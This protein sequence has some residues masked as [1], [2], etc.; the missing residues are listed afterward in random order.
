MGS[1]RV[2]VRFDYKGIRMGKLFF[3]GKS[4]EQ[5]AEETREQK[6]ALLRN[7]PVQGI[8]IQDIDMSSDIYTVID[9]F[10][11]QPVGYAPVIVTLTADSLDEVVGFIMKEEFRKIEVL[12]PEQVILNKSDTERL[13]F[14]TNE[15]LKEY[16]AYLERKMEKG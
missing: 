13:L 10:T 7:V 1:L 16:R 14:K 12:E 8:H 4:V 9:E 15:K 2:K 5:V 6:V 11:G 3:G